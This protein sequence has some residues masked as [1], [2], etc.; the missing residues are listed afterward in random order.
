[1]IGKAG[2]G[3]IL[4]LLRVRSAATPAATAFQVLVQ[5]K[6]WQPTNWE[7]FVQ[8]AG[9]VGARLT[10]FGVRKGDHVGIMAATSLDWEYAQMGALFAGAVVAG[11]DPEYPADQLN[12]VIE[13]LGLSVLFV[14][15]RSVFAKIP[16]E[17]RQQISVFI[18]FEGE[19][20]QKNEFSMINLLVEQETDTSICLPDVLPQDEAVIVFSSGTTGM[21]KAIIFTHEQVIMAVEAIMRG[22]ND[23]SSQTILLCW[24][25]L[26]NLFQ[27]IVNFC[28]IKIGASSYILSD[29]RDLMR[30]VKQVNPD[31]LIGVPKVLERV[32][33]GV[34]DH[35]EGRVWPLRMLAR[36]AIRI[37]YK[38]AAA[39][40]DRG[41]SFGLMNKLLWKQAENM[42]LRR[43]RMVFG[44]RVRYLVSG[45][46]AM[47]VW[48]LRW[49]DAIGLPVYEVYGISENVIP[50]AVNSSGSRKLG[51]VGKPLLPNEIKLTMD[52]EI[53][54][55]GP[56]VF[57]GYQDR[58][59]ES[60]LR[61]SP[62]GYWHTGDLGELDT[63]G[64]LSI[65]G[66][67]SDVF[68]T[69]A[70]KWIAPV[71]I[72]ERLGRIAYVEQSVVFQYESGKIVAVIVVDLEKCA[73]KTSAVRY[74]EVS[75]HMENMAKNKLH[76]ILETDINA[77]LEDLPLYQRPVYVAV[78]D[79]FFTVSGG[80]LTVNM[81]VRRSIVAQRFSAYFENTV[82]KSD[83]GRAE[84]G[85]V[86]MSGP[87]IFFI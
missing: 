11:I 27:R 15:N 19:S 49:F 8:A 29:P 34:V 74:S 65:V 20:Q 25:P 37:G 70:G 56:G 7:Q 79:K 2:I 68:K 80:E 9:R 40:S 6:S 47:P 45:S 30:Y 5:N 75:L 42:F 39:R 71:R 35:I 23:L 24:L 86:V 32:H 76:Q 28:A 41:D 33:S 22:F 83:Q 69:S 44:S 85:H 67:K 31:V 48:L 36:W 62:D 38:R 46:A 58:K 63:A 64:F 14:Q 55:R 72:E 51:A 43:L 26:S 61:F 13:N 4:D 87:T 10:D 60:N 53:L 78:T 77:E 66:R 3:T 52:G 21:P 12:H 73:Q 81:K 16:L 59:E 84:N 18:F 57:K 54:V 50:V 1:M 17:L 82:C